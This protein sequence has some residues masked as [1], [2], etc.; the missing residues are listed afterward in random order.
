MSILKDSNKESGFT[1]VELAVVM[2]IIGL[3]VGGILKGQEIVENA[4]LTATIAQIDAYR[5]AINT[6]FDKYDNLPG[7]LI[8]AQNRL[9]DCD[10]TPVTNCYQG[11]GNNQVGIGFGA[12][13]ADWPFE[14]ESQSMTSERIQL[15]VHLFKSDLING[16]TL[17]G[18]ITWGES[19][20]HAKLGVGGIDISHSMP[21]KDGVGAFRIQGRANFPA[22]GDLITS[23]GADQV[24][25]AYRLSAMDRKIDDGKG[26]IG[27]VQGSSPNRDGSCVN[28]ATGVYQTD[29]AKFCVPFFEI[30]SGL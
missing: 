28:A 20:P 27:F 29:I 6:F 16:I 1:L 18:N 21:F 26:N 25:S 12:T 9:P 4:R 7:D 30:G 2:T 10:G 14:T 17:T 5:A 11:D 3:L 24:V 15:W 23:A 13:L 22:N 19:H 8:N